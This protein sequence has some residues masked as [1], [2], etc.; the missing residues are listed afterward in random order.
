MKLASAHPSLAADEETREARRSAAQRNKAWTEVDGS[1][2]E[3]RRW[4]FTDGEAVYL[5][6]RGAA[7]VGDRIEFAEQLPLFFLVNEGG[8]VVL[9][10]RVRAGA[11]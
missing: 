1:R 11:A 3:R 4:A 5:P 6:H 7:F 9:L 10:E 8:D 2:L